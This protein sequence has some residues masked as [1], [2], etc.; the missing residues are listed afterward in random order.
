ME[1]SEIMLLNGFTSEAIVASKSGAAWDARQC[2]TQTRSNGTTYAQ[3]LFNSLTGWNKSG[4]VSIVATGNSDPAIGNVL[5]FAS[6]STLGAAC[7][8]QKTYQTIPANFGIAFFPA[9]INV[10]TCLNDSLLIQVQKTSSLKNLMLRFNDSGVFVFLSG[11]WRQ[12]STHSNTS[13]CEWWFEISEVGGNDVIAAYAGTQYVNSLVGV[14]PNGPSGNSGLVYIGQDSQVNNNRHSQVAYLAIGATQLCDDFS[15]TTVPYTLA[16]PTHN[17]TGMMLVEDVAN[18]LVLNTD[19]TMEL[20]VNGGAFVLVTLVDFGTLCNGVIDST[21]P[22]RVMA[23]TISASC[24]AGNTVR[25]RVK[26]LNH[27]FIG[28]HGIG[29]CPT[30]TY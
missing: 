3:E 24:S 16:V 7:F 5:D 8:A 4:N 9:I 22:V 1:G 29:V 10:G 11:S 15:I 6:G 21:K 19:I 23:G 30:S 2:E 14:L 26:A 13:F 28:L 18:S 25:A 17:L 20:S 12:L 27:K